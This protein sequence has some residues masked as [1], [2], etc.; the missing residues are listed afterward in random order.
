M[1]ESMWM[2][3][4]GRDGHLIDEFKRGFIAIGWHE[5]GDLSSISSQDELRERYERTYPDENPYKVGGAVGV[6]Y[7]FCC[8]LEVGQKVVTYNT[9]TREYMIGTIEGDYYYSTDEIDTEIS[10]YVHFR[11]VDW[12]G[13]VGRDLLFASS[14][15]TLGGAATLFSINEE[16]STELLSGLDNNEDIEPPELD[17]P[18][19]EDMVSRARELIKDKILILSDEEMEQLAAAILRAMGYRTRV[20]PRGRDRG[21]D[22]LA[23]P[24]GLGLEEPRI[25][26]EVKHRLATMG[27]QEI[28]S[29]LGGL[30]EGDRALYI[31]TGGFTHEA[32]YE[33]DR[34]NIPLTL[35]DLDDV[36]DLIANHY[37][38]F[39]VEGQVLMPLVKVYFPTE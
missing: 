20:T 1:A 28:R 14:R 36:A 37:E 32:K 25:R 29:F 8:V 10:D 12:I 23:S 26:V 30:R 34:S 5:L 31:S 9:Q 7:K 39:D 15:N 22:I 21:V 19:I 3:R 2:V 6:I 4:A 18:I 16:V 27:A 35:L 13:Q 11:Q 33:A 38:N 17:E 24:D